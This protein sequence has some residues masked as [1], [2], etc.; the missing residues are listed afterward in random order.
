MSE[1]LA[2]YS[3]RSEFATESG[4]ITGDSL[5]VG[6]TWV[7]AGDTD[8]FSVAGGVATRTAVSDTG[9]TAG[10]ASGR[11]ISASA[12]TS[13]TN[14]STKVSAMHSVT[15]LA[16]SG[17]VARYANINNFIA[18]YFI[19]TTDSSPSTVVMFKRVASIGSIP[20]G[21]AACVPSPVGS[22]VDIGLTVTADG[23]YTVYGGPRNG[24]QRLFSGF[25]TDLATGGA[26]ASGA[27]GVID[28]Q[29]S[30]SANT[31][32]YDSFAAWVPSADAVMF[33]SQSLELS[34]Q[35]ITREDAG[36]TAYGPVAV[37]TGDIP[38]M[39][40]RSSGAG[41]VEFMAKASRGDGETTA[42]PGIDD[43][44]VRAYRRTSYLT[45]S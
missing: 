7:G 40:N 5:A 30:A 39:P 27:A 34:T 32:T 43:I 28:F 20:D 13:M 31:R 11:L 36:G 6:G 4:A 23:N 9:G 14:T 24:M 15:G 21:R 35:G 1:G 25:D 37:V 18:V 22:Y 44:S 17:V 41:T 12:T 42:D 8:D 16:V 45:V 29:S 26:L 33:A 38:R 2:T 3:A 19:P 10:A